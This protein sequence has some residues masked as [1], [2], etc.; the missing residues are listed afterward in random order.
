M[1]KWKVDTDQTLETVLNSW[2]GIQVARKL[3]LVIR[4]LGDRN[5]FVPSDLSYLIDYIYYWI[6]GLSTV[7][8]VLPP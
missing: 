8:S 1:V 5:L 3:L 6:W 7:L 4:D 2:K